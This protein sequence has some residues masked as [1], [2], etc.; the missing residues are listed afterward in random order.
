MVE[1]VVLEPADCPERAQVC[2]A[3][4]RGDRQQLGRPAPSR[5]YFYYTVPTG[6]EEA[7]RAEW[8]DLKSAAGKQVVGFGRR[9]RGKF[10]AET[11]AGVA[12]YL[13]TPLG[14][15]KVTS[16]AVATELPRSRRIC[17]RSRR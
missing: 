6:H 12:G 3:C 1:K 13:S 16:R 11:K 9:R 7:A 10:R 2:G 5:G 8:M 15:F 17:A 4:A 14:V